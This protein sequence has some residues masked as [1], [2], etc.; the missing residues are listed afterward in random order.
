MLKKFV[1]LA[2]VLTMSIPAMSVH[3]AKFNTATPTV[4]KTAAVFDRGSPKGDQ[5]TRKFSTVGAGDP[6]AIRGPIGIGRVKLNPQPL[7]P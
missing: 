5:A 7:P 4:G 2:A 6:A 3:A 1:L